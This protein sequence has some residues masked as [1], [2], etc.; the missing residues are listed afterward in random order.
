MA[1][2]L[3]EKF[4]S[5]KYFLTHP[6]ALKLVISLK[7]SGYLFDEGWFKSFDEK[8]PV[9]KNGK[10]IPWFSYPSIEFLKEKLNDKMIV[11]E[12]GSGNSTLFFA[13][14]VKEIISIETDK[15]WYE[16]LKI[17][18]PSNAKIFLYEKD[19]SNIRYHQFIDSF[20][21]KFDIIVVDAIERNEVLLNSILHLSFNGIIILDDSERQ[22]Y[23][24]AIN[25][26]LN[27]GLK[28]IDFWGI[29]PGYF[30]KKCTTIF[31]FQNNVF[32]I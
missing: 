4:N 1:L 22:E 14:R 12:Y 32:N 15:Y 19:K 7:E 9:D 28:K 10:P 27:S 18:I 3:K 6:S 13:E 21:Q 23:Q 26:L 30:Y 20:E 25:Y 29:S 8:K 16:E 5:I 11:L 31:Y 2:T 17:R 24:S